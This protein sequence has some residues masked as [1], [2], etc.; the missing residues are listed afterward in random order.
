ME[1]VL[2]A[3]KRYQFE[4]L[5]DVGKWLSDVVFPALETSVDLKP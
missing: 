3:L 1:A 5:V 4:G 2:P